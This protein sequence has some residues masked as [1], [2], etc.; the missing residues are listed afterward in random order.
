MATV[1]L[2]A[3]AFASFAKDHHDSENRP[4]WLE[5]NYQENP[6]VIDTPSPR[7][8][9]IN[10]TE[11]T[12]WRILVATTK[13][14][15]IEDEADVWDSGKVQ[16]DESNLVLYKGPELE[17]MKDYYWSVRVWD[18]Q[19]RPSE[20]SA[21]GKWTTGM[22]KEGDWKAQWIGAPWQEDTNDTEYFTAPM[23]RKEFTVRKGLVSAKAFICGLG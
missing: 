3:F 19:D 20:W 11:Q 8:S 12:A 22:M 17:S 2:L 5:C 23:F 6:D 4:A 16:S 18:E 15:L 21:A 9:W 13:D 7:L 10:Q 1:V 14:L